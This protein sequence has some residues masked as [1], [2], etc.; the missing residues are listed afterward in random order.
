MS[1]RGRPRPYPSVR[2]SASNVTAGRHLATVHA[3]PA[4]DRL[5]DRALLE[6]L[7]EGHARAP[8]MLYDRFSPTVERTLVRIVGRDADIAGLLN[9]VFM[10]AMNRVDR[11]VDGDALGR[12]LTQ[13]AVFTAREAI[14]TRKRGRWLLFFDSNEL[15]EVEANN[16]S[17]DVRR[18]LAELY[19]ALDALPVDDRLVFTLRY[20]EEMD[21]TEVATACQ[22]SLATAKRRLARA[23]KR[24]V[25]ISAREPLLA[26][27][28]EGGV[29]WNRP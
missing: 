9:D 27:W 21:L 1:R 5:D 13:I 28:L 16:A 10:R 4:R 20:L 29:R 18:A 3:L 2:M 25:A 7:Q 14:R 19:H 6:A 8:A 24:F 12:W 22:V 23:E 26:S 11:V 17:P 15:P